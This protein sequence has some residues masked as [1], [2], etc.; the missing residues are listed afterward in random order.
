MQQVDI[1][2][3]I[4]TQNSRRLLE[5]CIESIRDSVAQVTYEMIV[6]ENGSTDGSQEW[7]RTQS[8]VQSIFNDKNRG[9]APARNQGL[10]VAQG[11]YLMI[12]DVDTRVERNAIDTLVQ[13]MDSHS[14]VG[15]GA[16]KLTDGSGELQFT[17]RH[18]PTLL[19]KMCRR[20][21][22]GFAREHLRHELLEDWDHEVE[23]E[24]DYVIGA[25]QIVR[26]EAFREVGE[27]DEKIFYG[28]EDIDYCVRMWRAGWKVMYFPVAVVRHLERRITTRLFTPM[29]FRHARGLAYFF[30][31]HKYLLTARRLPGS[32]TPG[33]RP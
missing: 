29:T 28:P 17:C 22:M 5:P 31:K 8:D 14:E 23:R 21:P 20:L 7:L 4:I 32:E 33:S 2:I 16:P 25:C 3:V 1:S 27:L 18:Y 11:R 26:R 9:V 15:L 19:S 10:R 13:C 12:L 30:W 6:V 24:V